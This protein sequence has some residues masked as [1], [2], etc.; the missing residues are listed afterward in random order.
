MELFELRTSDFLFQSLP[1][2]GA[3]PAGGEYAFLI[4]LFVSRVR[5]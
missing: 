3:N 1:K 2:V 5:R 4:L